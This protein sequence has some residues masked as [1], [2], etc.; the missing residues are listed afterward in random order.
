VKIGAILCARNED[1]VIE[2]WVAHHLALGVNRIHVFDNMST[3]DTR[4]KLDRIQERVPSVTVETW[5]P[6]SDTQRLAYNRGLKI[7]AEE[8]VDWC[9]FID[10]D[11]FICN[12]DPSSEETFSD[13]LNRHSDHSAIGLHWAIFGSAGHIIKPVGMLQE[14]FL[15]RAD[16]LFPPNR[17]IKSVVRPKDTVGAHHAHGFSLRHP[18]FSAAGEEISWRLPYA[19]TMSQPNIT[20]WRINHYFCQ[21]RDRWDAKVQRSK[22]RGSQSVLRTEADWI[23]HDRNEVLDSSA[24]RWIEKDR[25]MIA[26]IT[27]DLAAIYDQSGRA[28][29]AEQSLRQEIDLYPLN[30]RALGRLSELLLPS[31]PDAALDLAVRAV[32]ASPYNS[33]CHNRLTTLLFDRG[34]LEAV[35]V[36]LGQALAALPQDSRL[37]RRMSQ[38]QQQRGDV[39]LAIVW[40]ERA[41][42]VS[43]ADADSHGHLA[44]LQ[45]IAG[46][47]SAAREAA[48][49]ASA[50]A[51]QDKRHL[52][53]LS[54][55]ALKQRDLGIALNAAEQALNA[56]PADAASHHQ[57][58][59]VL[60]ELGEL[61]AAES[62][63][64]CAIELA[65]LHAG[66]RRHLSDIARRRDDLPRAIQLAEDAI[67]TDTE[68]AWSYYHYSTLLMLLTPENVAAAEAAMRRAAELDPHNAQFF[69]KCLV[70]S[71]AAPE[72]AT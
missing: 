57:M 37:L 26:K 29:L 50:A 64:Q 39:P 41:L 25:D 63:E 5:D 13:M 30:F 11:E 4:R 34:D 21:W 67:T 8:Q 3:D 31:D 61:S 28:D 23:E 12:G 7:M 14:N 65:P 2:E 54:D 46:N 45:M 16:D 10:T 68:D 70:K 52:R 38:V 48:A 56:D 18:Y 19:Y 62:A 22:V 9:A 44:S 35:E 27:H 60:V 69:S 6:P 47:L 43:P 71:S 17:H 20:G 42:A 36:A 49:R 24:L 1:H 51:P 40:V 58:A 55:I 15:L 53:R 59:S 33:D 66:Y 32:A 72:Q